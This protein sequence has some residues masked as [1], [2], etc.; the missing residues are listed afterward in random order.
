MKERV[1][2]WLTLVMGY[3]LTLLIPLKGGIGGEREGDFMVNLICVSIFYKSLW[4]PSKQ[5]M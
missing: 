3:F 5:A 2:L 1:T 4:K